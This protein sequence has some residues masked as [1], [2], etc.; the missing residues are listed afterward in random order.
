MGTDTVYY[1][2]IKLLETHCIGV[3]RFTTR[4]DCKAC[5]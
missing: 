3:K 4:L 1:Y 5:H 2:F